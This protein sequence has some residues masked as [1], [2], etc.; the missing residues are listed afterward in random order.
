[1]ILH[2]FSKLTSQTTRNWIDH[3]NFIS[4]RKDDLHL[5]YYVQSEFDKKIVCVFGC[6]IRAC[7]LDGHVQISAYDNMC[8][9]YTTINSTSIERKNQLSSFYFIAIGIKT[10]KKLYI[11][12]VWRTKY[13]FFL[14]C[15][16]RA[17]TVVFLF[18]FRFSQHRH[19]SWYAIFS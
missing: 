4:S 17:D 7:K 16:I 1:M 11:S 14:H 19:D 2:K 12:A 18:F 9:Y 5:Q 8:N 15:G 3:M 10:N 13:L 6:V